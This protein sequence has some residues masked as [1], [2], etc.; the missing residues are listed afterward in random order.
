[1]LTAEYPEYGRLGVLPAFG[2]FVRHARRLVLERVVFEPRQ[3]DRRPALACEDA[4]VE[5][6]P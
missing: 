6:C 5:G 4:A 2:A 3:A 1:M